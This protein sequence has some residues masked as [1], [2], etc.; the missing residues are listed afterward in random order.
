MRPLQRRFLTADGPGWLRYRY[1]LKP[2]PLFLCSSLRR[3]EVPRRRDVTPY[4]R[5]S[6]SI[7]GQKQR[8]LST[9]APQGLT[10]LSPSVSFAPPHEP[11]RHQVRSLLRGCNYCVHRS[12]RIRDARTARGVS[13][14]H[15]PPSPV[16]SG[17]GFFWAPSG[18]DLRDRP[19]HPT[20]SPIMPPPSSPRPDYPRLDE[21]CDRIVAALTRRLARAAE[22]ALHP[23]PPACGHDFLIRVP[24]P[25]FSEESPANS[26]CDVR[27]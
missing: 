16:L 19:N 24:C 11:P 2:T 17:E 14:H 5:F 21:T 3:R 20:S 15:F 22:Q 27:R 6:G 8:C 25:E 1:A 10:S 13:A 9:I 7:R 18:Q 26:V 23:H 12:G 4:P